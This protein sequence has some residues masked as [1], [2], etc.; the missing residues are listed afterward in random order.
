MTCPRAVVEKLHHEV[1]FS[2][3]EEKERATKDYEAIIAKA[4]RSL[5]PDTWLLQ[6][7]HA[8]NEVLRLEC[9]IANDDSALRAFVAAC[10]RYERVWAK[11]IIHQYNLSKQQNLKPR[12]FI[13][14]ADDFRAVIEAEEFIASFD[15]TKRGAVAF[16]TFQ[17]RDDG[18][19]DRIYECPCW[20]GELVSHKPE[21]CWYVKSAVLK[22]RNQSLKPDRLARVKQ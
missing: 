5:S 19:G 3:E 10:S 2:T 22:T 16:A 21:R 6:W 14:L 13:D 17:G 12:T 15:K 1:S 8:Y 9:K 18:K 20:T 7:R 11:N 4:G